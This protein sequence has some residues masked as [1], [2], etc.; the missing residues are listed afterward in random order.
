M[1]FNEP[2]MQN[3]I[4][5]RRI[6]YFFLVGLFRQLHYDIYAAKVD[7]I[8]KC[9]VF[10]PKNERGPFSCQIMQCVHRAF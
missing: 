2:R 3:H 5:F 4:N 9:K 1:D 8:N 10:C 6:V 7:F